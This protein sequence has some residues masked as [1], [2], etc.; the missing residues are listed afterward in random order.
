MK[1]ALQTH[2]ALEDNG[3]WEEDE[4][5]VGENV[6][7]GHCDKLCVALAAL[8]VGDRQYLPV[9][10]ERLAFGQIAYDDGH[11]G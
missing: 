11:K 1:L 2:M 6:A 4:K 8:A 10:I 9:L 7:G 5:Q 3:Y